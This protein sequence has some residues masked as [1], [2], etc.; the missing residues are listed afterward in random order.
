[1]VM[2]A[3][4]EFQCDQLISRYPFGG[5]G[6]GDGGGGILRNPRVISTAWY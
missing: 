4:K 3:F 6:S 5:E 2:D 1:M